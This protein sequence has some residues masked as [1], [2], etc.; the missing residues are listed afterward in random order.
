[1]FLGVLFFPIIM[2]CFLITFSMTPKWIKRAHIEKLVSRDVHKND[3]KKVAEGGGVVV[4]TGFAVGIFLYIAVKT[5]LFQDER[6]L[7]EIFGLL[8]VLLFVSIVGMIDD[9]LGWKKGLSKRTRIIL[10]L[11]SAVPLMVLN[12]GESTVLGI[13]FGIFFPLIIVPLANTGATATYNFLAGY[14]GLEASQ[15]II[16]LS[17]LTIVNFIEGNLW[18]SLITTCM[19]ASLIAFYLFN[20]YPAKI[21]PGDM[22]TY[23]IGAMIACIAILGDMEKI[24]LFFSNPSESRIQ[25][26]SSIISRSCSTTITEFPRSRR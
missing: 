4:L 22:L 16:L 11:F 26:A 25:S 6:N 5:F 21:F 1:M 15:G 14:N 7:I 20:K 17:A 2:I 3:G 13:N 10:L 12:V 8:G 18:L 19:I 9:L 24:V 23:S